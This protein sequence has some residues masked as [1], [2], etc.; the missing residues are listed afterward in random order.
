MII[1]G[2]LLALALALAT[3][4]FLLGYTIT[5]AQITKVRIGRYIYASSSLRIQK[6]KV[7]K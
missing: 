5:E 3:R 1:D 7:N 4:L 2:L 6:K